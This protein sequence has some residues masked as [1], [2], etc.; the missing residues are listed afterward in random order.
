MTLTQSVI[1]YNGNFPDGDSLMT[2]GCFASRT[3]WITIVLNQ[4]RPDMAVGSI[5]LCKESAVVSAAKP[6]SRRQREILAFLVQF[7]C[8]HRYPPSI[9]DIVVGCGLTSTS[10]ADYNLRALERTGHVQRSPHIARGLWLTEKGRTT[11]C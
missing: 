3:G 4:L 10:V 11:A 1:N 8:D 6:L 9:R 5:R 7:E 2:A